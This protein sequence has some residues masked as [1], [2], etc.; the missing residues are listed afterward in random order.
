MPQSSAEEYW[1]P[2]KALRLV[3]FQMDKDR[4]F[5]SLDCLGPLFQVNMTEITHNEIPVML[6]DL[7]IIYGGKHSFTP[8]I[9][10]EKLANH[11]GRVETITAQGNHANARRFCFKYLMT[12]PRLR[13]GGSG[14]SGVGNHRMILLFVSP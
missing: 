4:L 12:R 5:N 9:S 14:S 7:R 1:E 2:R 13:R 8:K 3:D 10:S 11:Q 6:V